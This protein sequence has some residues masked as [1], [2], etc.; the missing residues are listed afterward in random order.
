MRPL[1]HKG[2]WSPCFKTTQAGGFGG[3]RLCMVGGCGVSPGYQGSL[4][5]S[6]LVR[7]LCSK[8]VGTELPENTT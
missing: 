6:G 3:L 4:G 8:I 5:G 7:S 1:Q 2:E